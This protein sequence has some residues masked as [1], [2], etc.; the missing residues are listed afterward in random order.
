MISKA[1]VII[2]RPNHVIGVYGYCAARAAHQQLLAVRKTVE[3]TEEEKP[4][5]LINQQTENG[6]LEG[7]ASFY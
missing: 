6:E 2:T 1:C 5:E 3:V 7:I 4:Q